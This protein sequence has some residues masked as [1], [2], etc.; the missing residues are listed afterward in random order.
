LIAANDL[1]FGNKILLEGNIFAVTEFQRVKP[2]KGGAFVRT[3]LKNIKTG[4]V[5]DRTFRSEEKLTPVKLEERKVQFLY[6]AAGHYTF[7]DADNYEQLTLTAEQLGEA[8]DYLKE[9]ITLDILLHEHNPMG[10][11]LPIFVELAI[12]E[13]DPGVR[14]DTASGGSKPATLETGAVVSVPLF[15]NIGDIIKVDTRTGAYVERVKTG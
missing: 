4:A 13:T 1:R 14:G 12:A 7:M 8:K 15:L 6:E 3:K 2:G 11:N 9:N 10:V 5:I